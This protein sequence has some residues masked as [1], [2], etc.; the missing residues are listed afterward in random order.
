MSRRFFADVEDGFCEIEGQS[1]T[2]GSLTMTVLLVFAV[3][4]V[5]PKA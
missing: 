1:L 5:N 4:R 3:S 2:A